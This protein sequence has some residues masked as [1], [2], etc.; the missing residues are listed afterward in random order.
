MDGEYGHG[1][2]IKFHQTGWS[3]SARTQTPVEGLSVG[4]ALASQFSS[5]FICNLLLLSYL[6]TFYRS[7]LFLCHP[8]N[9]ISRTFSVCEAGSQDTQGP[10]QLDKSWKKRFSH[11]VTDLRQKQYPSYKH[12]SVKWMNDSFRHGYQYIKLFLSDIYILI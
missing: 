6:I 7:W 5:L 2:P 8:N 4:T 1:S 12:I 9:C 11:V 10:S 3:Y